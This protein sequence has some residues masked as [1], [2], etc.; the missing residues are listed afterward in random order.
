MKVILTREPGGTYVGDKIRSLLLDPECGKLEPE[1]EIFLMLAQ[2][3]EHFRKVILP[4]KNSGAVVL[5]DRYFDSSLAYQGFGRGYDPKVIRQLHE[6]SLGEFLPDIT[7][8]FDIDP[9]EGLS[10]ARKGG[11]QNFD[12]METESENF[13]YRVRAG[14]LEIAHDDPKR[15]VIINP[16]NSPQETYAQLEEKLRKKCDWIFS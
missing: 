2:R 3:I 11:R 15:Y 10:R 4:A 14:Y 9:I 5:C 8:L 16:D 7:L 6:K 1:T 13:H 12:R